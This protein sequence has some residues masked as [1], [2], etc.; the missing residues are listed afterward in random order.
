MQVIEDLPRLGSEVPVARERAMFVDA[1]LPGDEQQAAWLNDHTVVIGTQG[2]CNAFGLE[3]CPF[4]LTGH[5]V[6]SC[7]LK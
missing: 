7:T 2:H 5:L 4:K 3:N 6:S 1:Y